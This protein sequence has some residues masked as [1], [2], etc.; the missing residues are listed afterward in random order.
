[1]TSA[2]VIRW[3]A[4]VVGWFT[5][6]IALSS[7]MGNPVVHTPE[8]GLD[9]VLGTLP[10]PMTKINEQPLPSLAAPGQQIDLWVSEHAEAEYLRARPTESGSG[11]KLPVDTG[12]VRAIRDPDGR[13]T[14]YTALMQRPPGFNPPSDLWFAVYD[15]RGELARDETGATMQG[16]LSTCVSC[17]LTRVDDGFVFGAPES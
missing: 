8:P 3:G 2:R 11:I 5:Q 14:K 13:V 12:V 10:G 15:S 9:R 4:A 7:C 6:T 16:P 17:H 1:M